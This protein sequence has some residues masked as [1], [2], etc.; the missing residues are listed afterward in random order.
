MDGSIDLDSDNIKC[1][2]VKNTYVANSD[3]HTFWSD[4]SAQEAA[5]SGYT[6]GGQ[7][8]VNK[9][10]TQDN[11]NDKAAFDADDI[12]WASAT[13]IAQYAVIFKDTGTPT[14]SPLICCF[15]FGGDKSSSSG[16]FKIQWNTAGILNLN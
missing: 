8:L 13:I 1:A 12:T 6:A 9:T 5:G 10:V 4:V 7:L 2:L 14:T 3:T 11:I 16:D 15:D